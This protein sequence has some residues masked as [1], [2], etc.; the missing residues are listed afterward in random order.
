MLYVKNLSIEIKGD[1]RLLI[2]QLSFSVQAGDKIAIIGEEGNGKTVLLNAIAAPEKVQENFQISGEILIQDEL[3]GYLPQMATLSEMEC[4]TESLLLERYSYADLDWALYYEL[5]QMLSFP[6]E[7]ISGEVRVSEL[8]GGEKIKFFL[9]LELLKSPTIL[10]LDEP[11]ND[12][13]LESLAFLERFIQQQTIPILFVSHDEEL[14]EHCANGIIHLQQLRH[15]SR[16]QHSVQRLGY[17]DYL[18]LH[19][20]GI[21]KDSQLA[22]KDQEEYA[23]KVEKFRKIRD[24]VEQDLRSIEGRAGSDVAGRLLAKKM[25]SVKA[26]EGRLAREKESLR[27]KPDVESKILLSFFPDIDL[28]SQKEVLR[29]QLPELRVGDL[30]LAKNI[31]VNMTG[32]E[33][34]VIVGPNGSGKTTLLRQILPELEKSH[35]KIGYMPQNYVETM[36]PK[37]TPISYLTRSYEKEEQTR[38]RTFL[39]CLKFTAE[40]MLRPIA[41]LSGG[42]RAK[43]FF[44]GMIL[45]RAEI[46]LLDEPTR[47]L[48]PLS[49]PEIRAAL[50]AYSGAILA[51][52]HD[53]RFIEEVPDRVLRLSPEGLTD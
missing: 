12:L 13:D 11:S 1:H 5:L 20:A 7:R 52:S 24:K 9:L 34:V 40:E 3:I 21:L 17:R 36:D 23:I 15:K 47:N 22:A 38:I 8:S 6:E 28:P 53:R 48:S 50:K 26:Q 37:G 45:D 29:F 33:K 16:P 51:V 32:P 31:E 10:L 30:I 35:L 2:D 44:A 49:G 43:L 39:G 4:S 27:Q 41:T 46:L 18:E 14:L 25:R 42:Q 19:E